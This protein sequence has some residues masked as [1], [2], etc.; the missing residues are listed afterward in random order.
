M[1]AYSFLPWAGLGCGVIGLMMGAVL[2]GISIRE[3]RPLQAGVNFCLGAICLVSLWYLLDAIAL[4]HRIAGAMAACQGQ[5]Q[6]VLY[7]PGMT[8]CPGQETVITI[9]IEVPR[10]QDL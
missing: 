7:H 5:P 2:G 6:I 8:L 4:Q 10:G 1:V 9:E 3:R